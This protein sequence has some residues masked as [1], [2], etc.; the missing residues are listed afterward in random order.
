MVPS[1][2]YYADLPP[3]RNFFLIFLITPEISKNKK[4]LFSEATGFCS[5]PIA[6]AAMTEIIEH[7]NFNASFKNA[8]LIDFFAAFEEKSSY[9]QKKVNRMI[10]VL[11]TVGCDFL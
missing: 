4:I 11:L 10:A 1:K 6:F 9:K 5:A 2:L 8:S 7:F 3:T